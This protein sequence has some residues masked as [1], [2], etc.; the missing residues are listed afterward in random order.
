MHESMTRPTLVLGALTA[1]SCAM[2]SCASDKAAKVEPTAAAPAVALSPADQEERARLQ[3]VFQSIFDV[4]A[5]ATIAPELLEPKTLADAQNIVRSDNVSLFPRAD[6]VF[7]AHLA[8]KPDDLDNLTWHAQLYLAWADSTALT[9]KT[10]S[11]SLQKLGG[12]RDE[13]KQKLDAGELEGA[14]K[15]KARARLDEID[16]LLPLVEEV[17]GRLQ[18]VARE[19]IAIGETKTQAILARHG[20][21]YKGFRLGA[22]LARIS[23]DWDRYSERVQKLEQR[24]PDSNGLRFLK[25]V[26]AFSRDKDYAEAVR[27]LQEAIAKD[28]KF[29]KAQYYLALT[30]LNQRKFDD[31]VQALDRTLELSPGHPFANAVRSYITRARGY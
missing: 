24:N 6:A 22:D 12:Q 25:G 23:E 5:D 29:T 14:A 15:L 17:Q 13:L 11:T 16:W 28:P 18:Q 2:T 10:L 1:L 3:K 19:K 7:T 30:Y 9:G 20:D 26:V 4:P 27:F 8:Q 31:A 21:S